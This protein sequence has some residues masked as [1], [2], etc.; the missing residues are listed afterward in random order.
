MAIFKFMLRMKHHV[1]GS[2]FLQQDESMREKPGPA[3][4][5]LYNSDSCGKTSHHFVSCS[6]TSKNLLL[7]P[8]HR[9]SIQ[10]TDSPILMMARTIR[11]HYHATM[12]CDKFT[13]P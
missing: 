11:Q 1:W 9:A 3:E 2:S 5:D 4:S 8:F 12:L 6:Q 13:A 7:E 10:E